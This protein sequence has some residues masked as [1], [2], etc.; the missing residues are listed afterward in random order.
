MS[1]AP[2]DADKI[3]EP[4]ITPEMIKAGLEAFA[5]WDRGDPAEWKITHVYRAMEHARLKA[6]AMI[7]A[8]SGSSASQN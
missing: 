2:D 7:A 3:P 4:E 1:G 6:K 5:L 8:V